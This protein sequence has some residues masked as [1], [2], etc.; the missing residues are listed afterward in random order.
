[1]PSQD[2]KQAIL[3]GSTRGISDSSNFGVLMKHL[4]DA[5]FD[6]NALKSGDISVLDGVYG[7]W[8][9]VSPP[10]RSGGVGQRQNQGQQG[11]RQ[12]ESVILVPFQ[13]LQPGQVAT[14]AAQPQAA[15]PAPMAPAAPVAGQ[16]APAPAPVAPVAAVAPAPAPAPVATPVPP[17]PQATAQGAVAVAE[18]PQIAA[19]VT[20]VAPQVA[21]PAGAVDLNALGLAIAQTVLSV[22]PQGFTTQNLM[23]QVFASHP[24]TTTSPFRDQLA[25][26]I[27]SQ[28]FVN[29]LISQG[30]QVNGAT[31]SK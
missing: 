23:G 24:D 13:L 12:F 27:V 6:E 9:G 10:A 30:Y 1:M 7:Y 21:D 11:G 20:P 3:L 18:A 16:P 26:Y 29:V 5:G 31:I 2:G 8:D 4:V 25:N 22:N 15:A 17:A 19:P 28:D 14:V